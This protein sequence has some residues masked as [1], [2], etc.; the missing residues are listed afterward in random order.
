MLSLPAARVEQGR[1][2]GIRRQTTRGAIAPF[3]FKRSGDLMPIGVA[4]GVR[5]C[6]GAVSQFVEREAIGILHGGAYAALSLPEQQPL[7]HLR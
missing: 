3:G 1:E 2:D 5:Q 4:A 7:L 6:V